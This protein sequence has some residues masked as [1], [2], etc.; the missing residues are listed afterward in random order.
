MDDQQIIDAQKEFKIKKL[1]EEVSNLKKEIDKYRVL[2]KDLDPDAD[3]SDISDEEIIIVQQISKLKAYSSQRELTNDEVKNLD[4]Y[5]KNLR[6]IR[7]LNNR[8]K[9]AGKA[10]NLSKEELESIIKGS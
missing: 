10:K 2:L 5:V 8:D 9:S 7:G 6:L 4:L 1:E 3:V